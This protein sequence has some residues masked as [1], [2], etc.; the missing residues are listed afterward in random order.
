MAPAPPGGLRGSGAVP[1]ITIPLQPVK[2]EDVGH[3][4]DYYR[5]VVEEYSHRYLAALGVAPT[6]ANKDLVV[7]SMP[8]KYC[9]IH[10][11]WASRASSVADSL[12]ILPSTSKK[13][14][15]LHDAGKGGEG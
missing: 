8:L 11:S 5:M 14:G 13:K 4:E 9:E 3:P 10:A 12:T 6:A 7:K 1:E 15:I 2:E